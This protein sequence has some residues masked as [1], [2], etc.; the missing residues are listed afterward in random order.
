MW[1]PEYLPMRYEPA[2]AFGPPVRAAASALLP[3]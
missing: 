2:G 3:A 1:Y